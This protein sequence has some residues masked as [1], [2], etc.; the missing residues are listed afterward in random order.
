MKNEHEWLFV[1]LVIC[2]GFTSDPLTA[3]IDSNL[4]ATM[5]LDK[6]KKMDG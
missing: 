3:G 6:Q 4:S 2:P 5:N 1:F